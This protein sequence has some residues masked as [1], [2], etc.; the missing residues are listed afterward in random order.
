[1]TTPGPDPS[2]MRAVLQPR[3][4]DADVL[5]VGELDRPSIAASEVLVRVR[6]AG[7]DRGTWHVM[8]GLPYLG[9]LALGLRAPKA[10][11]PGLDVAGVVVAVG[12]EVTRFAAGD[13]VFGIAKGSFAE[14]AA[15]REDKLLPKPA[16]LTFEQAAAVPVSGLTA[17]RGLLDA[18]RVTAGQ[19]VLVT[20]ASGGV[21]TYAVQLA[22]ASGAEV[23]AVCSA[24]KADLVRGIG[25]DHVLD[26]ATD[27]FTDGARTYDLIL[28]IAGNT[29]LRRLRR[30]L[31][32]RGTLVIAGG[33]GGGR[34]FGGIDRQLRARLLSPFVRQRLT[35]FIARERSSE[36]ERLVPYLEGGRIV[37]VVG[38]TYPLEAA[39]DAMRDLV[40]GTARGKLVITIADAEVRAGSTSRSSG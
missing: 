2:R 6:A 25:A 28:D 14:Y 23:T 20:G 33:E 30:A 21:G 24:A 9:R 1:M 11:V 27:D 37:P 34:W 13:E 19:H 7:L 17:L 22:K 5:V 39:P 36:L 3:Y 10:A 16:V 4:G 26:Y 12:S 35:T 29:T 32:P 8:T 31:T 38:R 18:G 15:A 40:A